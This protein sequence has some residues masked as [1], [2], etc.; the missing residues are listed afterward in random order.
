MNK[1][2]AP[3]NAAKF[4]IPAPRGILTDNYHPNGHRQEPLWIRDKSLFTRHMPVNLR[5][6]LRDKSSLTQRLILAS[7]KQF[8]VQVVRQTMG[9]PFL[10][11]AQ[12]LGTKPHQQA[13]IRE[14]IL[15]GKGQP[16]VYARSILPVS[17]LKGR[18]KRLRKLDE[19]PLGALLFSDPS[20]RRGPL[21]F[22]ALQAAQITIPAE[23]AIFDTLLWARRSVFY[24][25]DKPLLVNEVFLPTFT[26]L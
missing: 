19:R 8:H 24:V 22:A 15:F 1:R 18:L 16:W 11:E 7:D 4:E 5:S 2:P 26:P 17:S 14:V 12:L 10:G 13:L 9:K 25:A 21:E 23:L 20:M 3:K 6:W